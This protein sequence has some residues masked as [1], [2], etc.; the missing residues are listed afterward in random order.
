MEK[1]YSKIA[2]CEYAIAASKYGM[3]QYDESKKILEALKDKQ[4]L[5]EKEEFDIK[6]AVESIKEKIRLKRGE[7]IKKD[8]LDKDMVIKSHR[9]ISNE[10]V[11][12]LKEVNIKPLVETQD[13]RYGNGKCSEFG[14]LNINK[15][16]IQ[17]LKKDIISLIQEEIGVM[18]YGIETDSFLNVFSKGA[19]HHHIRI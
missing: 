14:L 5:N 3:E 2:D 13:T 16:E 8:S 18:P 17:K 19:G 9:E 11:K 7:L 6:V 1:G 15:D 10:L 12:E 4:G